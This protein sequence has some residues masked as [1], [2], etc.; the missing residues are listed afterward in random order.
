M[1]KIETPRITA[2]P[3][4][5]DSP[6]SGTNYPADFKFAVDFADLRKCED[7]H[8]EK[9]WAAVPDVGGTLIHA[10]FPRSYL[11]VNRTVFDLDLSMIEDEW[12]GLV[13]PSKRCLELGNGLVFSKTTTLKSIYD[14]KLTSAE[15]KHRIDTCWNPYRQTLMKALEKAKQDA[16]HCWHLNLHSMPSNAYE[17]LGLP[18]G[19]KLADVVLGDLHG[20]ACSPEFTSVV[21]EAFKQR[22]YN[23]SLNDPYAGMDIIQKHGNPKQGEH[24]LQIELNRAAYLNEQTR[25]ALPQFSLVQ[26]DM[27]R[28][29]TDVAVY[30]RQKKSS[31]TINQ[32][33]KP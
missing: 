15:V 7:T 22:G 3:L 4:I 29:L 17:R 26:A 25:E 18:Q 32:G 28:V 30:I 14:R 2:I 31:S 19:R 12:R 20:V 24:S 23:V 9:L 33:S 11:D 16:Q 6:H 13:Q 5:C 1:V 27:T 21:S 8:V 10:S